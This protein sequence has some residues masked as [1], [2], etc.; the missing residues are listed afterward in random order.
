MGKTRRPYPAEHGGSERKSSQVLDGAVPASDPDARRGVNSPVAD[1][2]ATATPT[3]SMEQ[4]HTTPINSKH[5]K[6]GND[7]K[8]HLA[9]L[10]RLG[11]TR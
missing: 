6:N 7:S 3:Q 2:A 4:E 10:R 8:G 11:G 5:E 9:R 1:P